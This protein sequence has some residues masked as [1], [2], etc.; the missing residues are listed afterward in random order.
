[1]NLSLN[2]SNPSA[3]FLV[4]CLGGVNCVS[5]PVLRGLGMIIHPSLDR[6]SS[7]GSGS[8]SG[9]SAAKEITL[10]LSPVTPGLW[11]MSEVLYPAALAAQC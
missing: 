8:D 3:T 11:V 6:P 10:L 9:S 2:L 5:V 1:M 7:P 4:H